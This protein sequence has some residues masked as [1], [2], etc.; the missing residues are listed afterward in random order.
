MAPC[1]AIAVGHNTCFKSR[2][3]QRFTSR[4]LALLSALA[5]L[6]SV[7]SAV[8]QS[9]STSPGGVPVTVSKS[10]DFPQ[11]IWV[12]T[13]ENDWFL[14]SDRDYTGGLRLAYTTPNASDWSHLPVAGWLGSAFNHVSLIDSSAAQDAIG[15]YANLNIYTPDILTLDPPNAKDHP[16]AGWTSVGYDLIRQ[17]M[18][19]RAIFEMNFGLVGP[20]SGAEQLQKSFHSLIGSTQPAG[21]AYQIKDEPVV[22]LTYRQDWRPAFLTN[23][24]S[25]GSGP[26]NYDVIGHVLGTAGN[27]FD[28]AA[29]GLIA[30]VGYHLPADFGVARPRLG[31]IDSAPFQ[32]T[33]ASAPETNWAYLCLGTEARA[34]ARDITVDGNTFTTNSYSQVNH[35]PFVA[36]Y[37]GGA[38]VEYGWFRGSFLIVYESHTFN[39]QS[40]AGQW[41]GILSLGVAF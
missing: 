6:F 2:P 11:G 9:T 16:Y 33:G 37:Y 7:H 19:R 12:L 34:V 25:S 21:W 35:A 32:A 22:Q 27:G 38:A 26:I 10:M 3:M 8:A 28:Y 14:Y 4:S 17:T 29:T 15:A 30:R 23:L 40:Q 5:T 36:E 41:R 39:T 13:H 20:T 24:N 18:D 31:E 1:F